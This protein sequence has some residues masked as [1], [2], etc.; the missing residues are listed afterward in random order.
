[1]YPK[2]KHSVFTFD[3]EKKLKEIVENYN[4]LISFGNGRSYGDSA[5]NKYII[6]M[7]PHHSFI[8]FDEINGVLHVQ[9]GI[10]L[11]D[12]L[13]VIVPKGWFL[14]VT[15]GTQLVTVGGA[16]ASDV[17]GKNHHI[18][19]CFSDSIIMFN[20]MMPNGEIVTCSKQE[21]APLFKATCGGMG[22]TGIIYSCKIKLKKIYR[23][24]P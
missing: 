20:L 14:K 24:F 4:N 16:I 12:I 5:L 8:S 18:D 6:N 13:A 19:G 17:H 3:N 15:P 9:S 11:S 2:I 21:N 1:M 23:L 22:L 10:L 7:K